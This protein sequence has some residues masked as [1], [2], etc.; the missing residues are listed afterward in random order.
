MLFGSSMEFESMNKVKKDSSHEDSTKPHSSA[1][2]LSIEGSA[3]QLDPEVDCARAATRWDKALVKAEIGILH[4]G[5]YILNMPSL[6]NELRSHSWHTSRQ[7][8]KCFF[9]SGPELFCTR[10]KV[11]QLLLLFAPKILVF[12]RQLNLLWLCPKQEGCIIHTNT[13]MHKQLLH[14]NS[15]MHK[16]LSH[17]HSFAHRH[18][19]TQTLLHTVIFTHT[20]NTHTHTP[21]P[22]TAMRFYA[23]T[24]FIHMPFYTQ[25]P[26]H[27]R[28][29]THR[30]FMTL[31]RTDAFTHR[32]F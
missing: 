28:S 29:C 31:L 4:H 32:C 2:R 15:S 10:N 3:R 19:Y 25:M 26:L 11:L 9:A 12:R 1:S 16:Q 30:H 24:H 8:L 18:F 7:G 20:H 14:T 22:F 21:T 27:T 5:R 13:S 17:T 23:Q 6:W